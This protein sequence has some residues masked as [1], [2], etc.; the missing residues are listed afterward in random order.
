M[1]NV[2]VESAVMTCPH[3]GSITLNGKGVALLKVGGS[4]A[5]TAVSILGAPVAGCPFLNPA[6]PNNPAPCTVVASVSGQS[7]KVTAGAIVDAVIVSAGQV[8]L[9]ASG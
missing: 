3:G 4:N 7:G 8:A 5:L 2:C 6:P 1:A 9:T